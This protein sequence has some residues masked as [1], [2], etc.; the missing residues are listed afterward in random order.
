MNPNHD[1]MY[2]QNRGNMD[3]TRGGYGKPQRPP[4]MQGGGKGMGLPKM[5]PTAL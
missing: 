2:R 1:M 4:Q 5:Q 3:G